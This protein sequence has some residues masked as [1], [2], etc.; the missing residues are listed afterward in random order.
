M[1]GRALKA[2][3]LLHEI[4]CANFRQTPSH[5]C[6]TDPGTRVF[7]KIKRVPQPSSAPIGSCSLAVSRGEHVVGTSHKFK[8]SYGGTPEPHTTIG[9]TPPVQ[10]PSLIT[11]L[12]F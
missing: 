1:A 11:F 9:A 7:F 12:K 4:I 6:M 10:G 8:N 2:T 5:D 3:N